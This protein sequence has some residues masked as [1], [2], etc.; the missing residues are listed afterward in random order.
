MSRSSPAR[1]QLLAGD[2][3]GLAQDVEPLAGDLADDPDA[4]A[5]AGERLPPDDLLGQARARSPTARTS[6]LNSVR[7]G[8]TSSNCRSSGRPPTLWWRLDVGGAGAAA[9]LD[10]VGVERALHEELDRLARRAA[11]SPTISRSACLEDPDE[12]AADDLALLLGVGDPGERV[13]EAL[14]ARR[15]RA[16]RRRSRRRS[17]LDLL[18]LALAQQPV[19]DEHAGQLVA[20]GPLHERRGDRGVDAAGQAADRP[21][22]RRPARGSAR[23]APRRCW[24]SSRSAGSRRCRSRK[25][26]STCW[27]CS[28][29]STSGCH[30]TPASRRS[31]SSN[32]ATGVAGGGGQ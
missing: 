21:A 6:S 24:P 27:P 32:A 14:L 13:E 25:C 16:G 9:G 26:S 7:S 30:C 3:V 31:T 5:G 2:R 15:R 20:D 1:G 28:V 11:A 22:G 23:P 10:D 29:C 12:L 18:G 17:P 4:E 8:S 19:V